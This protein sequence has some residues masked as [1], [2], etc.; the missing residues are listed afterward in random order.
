MCQWSYCT[1][2]RSPGIWLKVSFSP[3]WQSVHHKS[4]LILL[5]LCSGKQKAAVSMM[6]HIL[7]LRRGFFT[8]PAFGEGLD[9]QVFSSAAEGTSVRAHG[10][11]G[12]RSICT[13]RG[14]R[15]LSS[16]QSWHTL[17]TLLHVKCSRLCSQ[18]STCSLSSG[19]LGRDE[20]HHGASRLLRAARED[21]LCLGFPTGT[22]PSAVP[23]CLL[24]GV[25][26]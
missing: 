9:N 10:D 20:L 15:R 24:T 17:R 4:L 11:P 14:S 22:L 6:K 3:F 16:R 26:G 1:R 8:S 5:S 21:E 23:T 19:A 12:T 13:S 25:G 7:A 18:S 2:Y